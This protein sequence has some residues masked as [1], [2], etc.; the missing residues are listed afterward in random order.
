LVSLVPEVRAFAF[1]ITRKILE[2]SSELSAKTLTVHLGYIFPG[3]S[4]DN[5]QNMRFWE[6]VKQSLEQLYNL[7]KQFQIPILIENGS[8]YLTTATS[9]TRTPLHL[10]ISPYELH[11]LLS[12]SN[13]TLGIAFDINKAIQSGYPI[14]DFIS[15]ISSSIRQVQFSTLNRYEDVIRVIKAISLENEVIVVIF[16]GGPLYS[17][18]ALKLLNSLGRE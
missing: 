14:D 11:Y 5:M 4:K 3:W 12:L 2:I 13:N 17:A 6:V 1:D 18:Q 9:E 15:L 16:E 7:S 10:G 8:Y